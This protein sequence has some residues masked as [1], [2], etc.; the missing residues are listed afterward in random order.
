MSQEFD[1]KVLDLDEQKGFY[2]DEYISDFKKLRKGLSSKK[3]ILYSSLKNHVLCPSHYLS[4]LPLSW[5]AMLDMTNVQ[6]ERIH[7]F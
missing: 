3:K 4:A 6:L 2:P 7:Y 1:I 5:D